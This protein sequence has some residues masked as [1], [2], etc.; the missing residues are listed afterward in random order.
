MLYKN[1]DPVSDRGREQMVQEKGKSQATL[2][3]Y[4]HSALS[5][6]P[7]IYSSNLLAWVGF[8][9]L[10]KDL[11]QHMGWHTPS[12]HETKCFGSLQFRPLCDFGS[13]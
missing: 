4:I 3:P 9:R 5:Y 10:E 7:A 13:P 8:S 11:L 1:Q 6:L 12:V 2:Q